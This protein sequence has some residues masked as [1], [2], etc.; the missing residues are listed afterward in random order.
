[1]WRETGG[2]DRQQENCDGSWNT[3]DHTIEREIA[4]AE[5]L[6][7]LLQPKGKQVTFAMGR[8]TARCAVAL[9]MLFLFTT[10]GSSTPLRFLCRLVGIGAKAGWK[11][12]PS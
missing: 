3:C 2:E 10:A 12:H 1:V 8:S 11:E 7:K 9:L 6:T 4:M 5:R